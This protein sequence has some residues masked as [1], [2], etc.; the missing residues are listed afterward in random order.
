MKLFTYIALIL[1]TFTSNLYAGVCSS[2]I[3]QT[4]PAQSGCQYS[5]KFQIR[6]YLKE[7]VI[8]NKYQAILQT[9]NSAQYDAAE[10]SRILIDFA[11]IHQNPEVL[12]LAINSSPDSFKDCV[13][14]VDYYH[15]T[16]FDDL[17]KA[18]TFSALEKPRSKIKTASYLKM[19]ASI[20]RNKN[21]S[22]NEMSRLSLRQFRDE[23]KK[24]DSQILQ[25]LMSVATEELTFED[26]KEIFGWPIIYS[27][28][29]NDAAP[30][31]EKN[32]LIDM[33]RK[34]ILSTFIMGAS[35]RQVNEPVYQFFFS[36]IYDK[37]LV[38]LIGGF[39]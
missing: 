20:V 17:L 21:F 34:E 37:Q 23:V 36:Q 7:L 29:K 8:T 13:E 28:L 26:I 22:K 39:L 19:A 14:T 10:I 32:R 16:Q 4:M 30:S 2:K 35:E 18:V 25:F 3:D 31:P 15:K 6:T 38:R 33:V 5:R 11:I 1:Y 9:L 24:R 12:Q 27:Y